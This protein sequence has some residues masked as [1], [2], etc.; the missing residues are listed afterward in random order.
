MKERRYDFDMNYDRVE[1]PIHIEA[2]RFIRW[3]FQEL[4]DPRKYQD[5]L[6]EVRLDL[7]SFLDRP[8][9]EVLKELSQKL[10]A[11]AKQYGA[12]IYPA[13]RI[14]REIE[15]E[16]LD[17]IGWLMIRRYNQGLPKR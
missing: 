13:E 4:E 8:Q 5:T 3:T 10:I 7:E 12:P 15:L 2:L 11:G 9:D 16:H 14:D 6:D 1:S 17:L